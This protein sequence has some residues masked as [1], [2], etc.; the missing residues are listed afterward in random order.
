MVN[1]THKSKKTLWIVGG[2]TLVVVIIVAIFV[3]LHVAFAKPSQSQVQHFAT[4]TVTTAAQKTKTELSN[5]ISK[6]DLTKSGLTPLATAYADG[7]YATNND[8]LSPWHKV[9][10]GRE[11]AY[12]SATT[13]ASMS[14]EQMQT[15]L[16]AAGWKPTTT[17]DTALNC[18]GYPLATVTATTLGFTANYQISDV[19]EPCNT[20]LS[21]TRGDTVPTSAQSDVIFS[22]LGQS[23]DTS[24]LFA[25]AK[26]SGAQSIIAVSVEKQYFDEP[27]SSRP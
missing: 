26:T 23:V 3:M 4:A 1:R 16:T 18:Y 9:C 19:N 2:I 25:Q 24:A 8:S 17:T 6:L 5:D 15:A 27:L 20:A 14:R 22:S 11:V 10:F 12:F 21:Q 13:S 7:C